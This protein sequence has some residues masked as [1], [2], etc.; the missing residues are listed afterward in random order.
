MSDWEIEEGTEGELDINRIEIN[1]GAMVGPL[2]VLYGS[3][4]AGKTTTLLR[5]SKYLKNT[6]NREVTVNK[7]FRNSREYEEITERFEKMM[8]SQEDIPQRTPELG[9]CLIDVYKGST[10]EFQILEASGESF[11]RS[12]KRSKEGQSQYPRYLHEI[13]FT[14][15]LKRVFVFFFEKNAFRDSE[16][17]NKEEQEYVASIK[18]LL[19][20]VDLQKHSLVFL[21]NKVDQM[22]QIFGEGKINMRALTKR[23]WSNENYK[24]LFQYLR[25]QNVGHIPLVPFSSGTFYQDSNVWSM[26]QDKYPQRLYAAI[27]ESMEDRSWWSRLFKKW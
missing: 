26:S 19:A 9:F 27:H 5:L 10:L 17:S 4:T 8:S 14:L 12:S 3:K 21:Y 24:G 20:Q 7:D 11:Y 22:A 16:D 15:N 13:L 25:A 1:R 18:A 23:F 2:I 6:E